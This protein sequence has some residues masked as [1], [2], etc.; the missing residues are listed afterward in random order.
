MTLILVTMHTPLTDVVFHAGL[1]Q[2]LR[3]AAL[4]HNPSDLASVVKLHLRELI[5]C[6]DTD[7]FFFDAE[8]AVLWRADESAIVMDYQGVLGKVAKSRLG[9]LV[10]NTAS[11]PCFIPA[12]DRPEAGSSESLIVE[13][14]IDSS[15]CLHGVVLLARPDTE[16]YTTREQ[17]RLAMLAQSVAVF[18]QML[19]FELESAQ[20]HEALVAGPH[21]SIFNQEALAAHRNGVKAGPLVEIPKGNWKSL[22]RSAFNWLFDN[23]V[24]RLQFIQQLDASDCGAACLAM[25]LR[26]FGSQLPLSTIRDV[27]NA[28]PSGISLSAMLE[29]GASF[30]LMVRAIRIQSNQF[31][32]LGAGMM[33]HW[34]F[35]HLVVFESACTQGFVI[36]DPA[37]GRRV[38]SSVDFAAKFTGLAL[39]F[40]PGTNFSQVKT[41]DRPTVRYLKQLFEHPRLL[42]RALGASLLVQLFGMGLPLL[43]AV[44]I[45]R[46]LPQA[47]LSL[48]AI[49]AIGAASAALFGALA[50]LARSQSLVQLRA[51]FDQAATFKFVD[52]LL[53]LPYSFFQQR[54]PGD[55]MLRVY[56]NSSIREILSSTVISALL[57]GGMALIYGVVLACLAPPLAAIA[58]AIGAIQVGLVFATRS[59]LSELMAAEWSSR[60]RANSKL[61]QVLHGIQTLK[62]AGAETEGFRFWAGDFADELNSVNKRQIYKARLDA[63]THFFQYGGPVLALCVGGALV[64]KGAIPLGG[65]LAAA[66]LSASF[67]RPLLELVRN[68]ISLLEVQVHIERIHDV[69]STAS[70]STRSITTQ[71]ALTGDIELRDLT[72][73]YP[74]QDSPVI[75]NLSFAVPRGKSVAIVGETGC[76]KSTLIHLILGFFTP[77]SGGILFD[78]RDISQLNLKLLRRQIGYVPQNPYLFEG[79]VRENIALSHPEASLGDIIRAARLACIHDDIMAMDNGYDTRLIANG[80]SVSGGQR[81]RIAIARA[82]LS[83]PKLLILDEATSALDTVTEARLARNLD[84]LECT[85]I[86]VAHRL[87]TIQHANEILV[88]AA[89]KVFESGTHDNLVRQ[90]GIYARLVG[91]QLA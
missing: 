89:G 41:T 34:E 69:V 32:L 61:V 59:N 14:I 78:G 77:D 27:L 18:F 37:V 83:N 48:L 54:S 44:V 73:T 76:G 16:P 29:L 3:Q 19:D 12:S 21:D 23:K 9:M 10:P 2:C 49:V 86:I 36:L 67:L 28:G 79:S 39:E 50:D 60:A 85:R 22:F 81:Q 63:V 88:V 82:L 57:D 45:D 30:G 46:V 25:V 80:E 42:R 75:K 68:S 90:G 13:P 17:S 43:T 40:T 72:F 7:L 71:P 64:I 53:S 47:N 51:E 20:E 91:A 70:E 11:E 65:M 62:G 6:Q 38:V 84:E 33:L 55:L 15:G 24:K 1:A 56:A 5:G 87:S 4:Q 35:N 74:G 31:E 52:H 66:T 8:Q 26:H 58:F